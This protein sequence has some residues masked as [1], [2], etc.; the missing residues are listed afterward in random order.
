MK[1]IRPEYKQELEI[2]KM[3]LKNLFN[4]AIAVEVREKFEAEKPHAV[5]KLLAQCNKC[6]ETIIWRWETGCTHIDKSVKY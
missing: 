6:E 4:F 5:G 2:E 3:K 1:R